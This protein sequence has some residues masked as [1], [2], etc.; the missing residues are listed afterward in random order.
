MCKT[1]IKKNILWF[2]FH[3]DH[4]GLQFFKYL[5]CGCLGAAA[6]IFAFYILALFVFP[7]LTKDDL[8]V[9]IFGEI[10]PV[11]SDASLIGR[12]FVIASIGG[13]IASGIVSYL[14][15]IW[16]V[17]HSDAKARHKE[18]LM[19]LL[20]SIVNIPLSTMFGLIFMKLSSMATIGY[21]V[22]MIAALLINFV[23]RKY[24]VFKKN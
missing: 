23:G 12:N 6:D 7:A 13:F 24:F 15:N 8:L 18:I 1:M 11:C 21:I 2:V 10:V 9:R 14:L 20:V 16:F 5:I 22:K 19:F 17:F 4:G 3:K